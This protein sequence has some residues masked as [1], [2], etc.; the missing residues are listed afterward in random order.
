[1]EHKISL[2][3]KPVMDWENQILS[4]EN[5]SCGLM[6]DR[7]KEQIDFKEDCVRKVLLSLGWT[8]PKETK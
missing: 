8:P 1:M 4:F 2:T 5:V 6:V 3:I 7:Y